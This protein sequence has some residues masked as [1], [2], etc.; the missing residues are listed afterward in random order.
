MTHRVLNTLLQKLGFLP[1]PWLQFFVSVSTL[2]YIGLS[3]PVCLWLCF[4]GSGRSLELFASGTHT[5]V[6]GSKRCLES[7]E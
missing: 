5:V 6:R 2:I 7:P 1:V 3:V 4:S